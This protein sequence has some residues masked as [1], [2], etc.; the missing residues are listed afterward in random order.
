MGLRVGG[1]PDKSNSKFYRRQKKARQWFM[2]LAIIQYT[3]YSM[4]GWGVNQVKLERLNHK[5]PQMPV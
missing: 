1:M 5:G 3:E 2:K 4:W